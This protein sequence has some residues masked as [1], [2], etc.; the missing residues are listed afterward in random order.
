VSVEYQRVCLLATERKRRIEKLEAELEIYRDIVK[1]Y[2]ESYYM[3]M[4]RLK[5]ELEK[6]K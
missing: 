5:E 3:N 4:P 1:T 6:M 2:E